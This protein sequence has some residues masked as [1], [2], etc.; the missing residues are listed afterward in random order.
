[1][2]VGAP[3]QLALNL[4]DGKS[5]L[6]KSIK[7]LPDLVQLVE[8]AADDFGVDLDKLPTAKDDEA[9]RDAPVQGS[10]TVPTVSQHRLPEFVE[11]TICEEAEFAEESWLEHIRGHLTELAE[12]QSQL[13]DE[14]D[15]ITENLHAQARE[16]SVSGPSFDPVQRTLSKVST[17]LSRKSTQLRNKSVDSVAEEI[18]RMI[19]QQINE[20]RLSHVLT[21][22]STQSEDEPE[23]GEPAVVYEDYLLPKHPYTEP[24]VELQDRVADRE[25]LL[26]QQQLQFTSSDYGEGSSPVPIERVATSETVDFEPPVVRMAEY[27]PVDETELE[28]EPEA[29]ERIAARGTTTSTPRMPTKALQAVEDRSLLLSS[30]SEL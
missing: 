16:R 28:L 14:L 23:L 7:T 27:E 20:R 3:R 10:S 17:G 21:R 26:R 25:R 2:N 18:P 8:S 24:I 30:S 9:F 1:L 11:E 12:A 15:E 4:N 19:D 29:L 6:R 13:M 5:T 22:G